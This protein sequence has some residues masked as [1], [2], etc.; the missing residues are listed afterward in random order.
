MGFLMVKVSNIY[1]KALFPQRP[2]GFLLN[3]ARW[4]PEAMKMTHAACGSK[5]LP[6]PVLDGRFNPRMYLPS[7]NVHHFYSADD[8]AI[9]VPSAYQLKLYHK[10]WLLYS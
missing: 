2:N 7:T 8:I 9:L 6:T 10:I 1:Q 3:A 4:E 5:T